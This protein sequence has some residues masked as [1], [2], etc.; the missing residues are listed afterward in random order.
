MNTEAIPFM[1]LLI[2]KISPE[3]LIFAGQ[4]LTV[5]LA[6]AALVTLIAILLSNLGLRP[7]GQAHLEAKSLNDEWMDR[8][9]SLESLFVTKKE[10]KARIKEDRENEKRRLSEGTAKPRL[11]VLDFNGDVEASRTESLRNEITAIL[12][13]ANRGAKPGEPT[14]EVLLRLESPGGSVTGYGLAASQLM[15]LRKAGIPLTIAID[16]VAASGGYMMAVVANRIVASPFA[17]LGSIGVIGQVP[18]FHRLL[19]KHDV[20]YLEVTAGE[21]KRPVSML[22]PVTDDGVKKFRSQI[23]DVHTL[24]REHVKSFRPQLDLEKTANG[25]IWYGLDA[26]KL[27]LID[28]VSTSDEWLDHARH[29]ENRDVFLLSWKPAKGWKARLEDTA[30]KITEKAIKRALQSAKWNDARL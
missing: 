3:L 1:R 22:G 8:K 7:R 18:N 9:R 11:W 6:A 5:L 27:G 19:K 13:V 24:F 14:D 15:R 2:E 28:H 23:E 10:W 26:L 16:E 21:H 4:T 17:V 30:G 25:D 12:E 29:Q 20:D